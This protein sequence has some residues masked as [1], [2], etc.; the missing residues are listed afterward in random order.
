M[1]STRNKQEQKN[2]VSSTYGAWSFGNF[3]RSFSVIL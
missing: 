3:W 2:V 1:T